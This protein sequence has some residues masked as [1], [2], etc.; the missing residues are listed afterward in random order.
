[1]TDFDAYLSSFPEETGYL[2]WAA[3]GP[4]SPLVRTEV[5]ADAELL[6]S[7]RRS[8]IDL[9]VGRVDDARESLAEMLGAPVDQVVLQPSTSY[10]LMHAIYGLRGTVLVSSSDFPSL[11]VSA[12]RSAA[13]GGAHVSWMQP[14]AGF[15]T[16]EVVRD[17]LTDDVTAVALSL[18]DFHTGY[19]ADLAAI[20]EVIG[21]RLL[22]VDAIQGFGVVDADYAA[23]DVVCGNGYTWLRAGRGTG[24]AWFGDRALDR[25]DP[26]LSGYA[27]VEGEGFSFDEVPPPADSARAFTVSQVD[28]LA[29]AR[30]AAAVSEVREAGVARIEES[31]AERTSEVIEL[32][33]RYD[34]PLLT[35]RDARHRAG[36]VAIAPEA[37]DAAPLAAALANSGLAVTSRAGTVRISTH[38]GTSSET[39]A[40]LADALAAFA[41]SRVW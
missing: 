14:P 12:T 36:I 29:A 22:I 28:P 6:C 8:S 4:L 25:L 23:A 16:P 34:L 39:V 11:T 30:L 7:G 26:I 41:T 19:R 17:A 1:M 5:F 35:P 38:A 20:R 2:D 9:V 15:V 32:I 3:F 37:R 33:D 40:Q 13:L 21:D 27:G 24:Y 10:G 18:V 31:V